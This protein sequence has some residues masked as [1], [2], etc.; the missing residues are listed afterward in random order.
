MTRLGAP[1]GPHYSGAPLYYEAEVRPLN[2]YFYGDIHFVAPL[3]NGDGISMGGTQRSVWVVHD[4]TGNF[5]PRD[6]VRCD[7]ALSLEYRGNLLTE[8]PSAPGGM[9]TRPPQRLATGR[10][11]PEQVWTFGCPTKS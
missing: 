1:A 4:E 8:E 6:V 2:P 7:A 9:T 3:V 10:L 11:V 5:G